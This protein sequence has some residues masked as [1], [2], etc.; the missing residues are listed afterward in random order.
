MTENTMQLEFPTSP[1]DE[2]TE[3]ILDRINGNDAYTD[4]RYEVVKAIC[5]AAADNDGE[6]D[7]NEVRLHLDKVNAPY[8]V[9]A[10]YKALAKAGILVQTGWSVS[11]DTHGR[12]SGKPARLYTLVEPGE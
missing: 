1:I 9:G 11:T 5:K 7:P 4:D 6:V 10:V 3:T 2:Q 12:N 8:V